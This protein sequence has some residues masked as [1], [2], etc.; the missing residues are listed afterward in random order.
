VLSRNKESLKNKLFNIDLILLFIALA[1]VSYS[2]IIAFTYANQAPLDW[3]AFRQTQTALT[4]YWFMQEGFK[5]AYETPVGGR[6]WSIP[7]EFI[8]CWLLS[9]PNCFNFH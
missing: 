2:A 1:S 4:A 7:F 3:Y 9:F 6:P 8:K 5:L